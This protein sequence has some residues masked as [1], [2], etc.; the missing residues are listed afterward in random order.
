MMDIIRAQGSRGFDPDLPALGK[1]DLEVTAQAD[2]YVTGIDNL[3]IARIAGLAGAPKV[4]GAGTE[5]VCKLGDSVRKGDLLYRVHAGFAAD[6]SFARQACMRDS[7]Y[8]IGPAD[9][10]QHLFVEF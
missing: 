10:V 6:L 9:S 5:L 4:R 3:Q 1:L 8:A 2:G 7:G